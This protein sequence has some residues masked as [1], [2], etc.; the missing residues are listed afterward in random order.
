MRGYFT[1]LALCLTLCG[2]PLWARAFCFEAAAA[3]YHVSPLLIKSIAIGESGLDPHATNDNRNKKTGKIISTDYG[4][5]QV[6]SGHIPRLVAMGVI[7]D[8]NDLLNHP[9]LN[10]QIG[11]WIL[12][13]HFQTCGVSWNCLGSYNAGF[14]PDRHETRERYANRIWKIYQRQTGAKWQ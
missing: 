9:C 4:L 8:K 1:R 5:M 12:A 3:K 6:N 2:A 13:T 11:T 7:Q 10:V 14:R